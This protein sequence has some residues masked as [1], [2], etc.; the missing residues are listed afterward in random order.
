M[1]QLHFDS[2]KKFPKN[3]GR[4]STK[5]LLN[6]TKKEKITEFTNRQKIDNINE[7]T[8]QCLEIIPE[9]YSLPEMPR[10]KTKI[11]PNIKKLKKVALFDLDETIVH[12]I[13]E[14]NMNN[15]ENFTRQSDA[16]IKV[17]LPG[18][19]E[20]TIG[21]NIRPHWEEALNMIKDKYHIIAYTASHESYAD[22]VLKYLDPEN[23]YFEYKLYRSHCVLCSVNDMK[24][25]VKDL[26]IL[27]DFCD[28]KEVVL[29]DNSVLSFA[30][31]LDNGI[32]ISPFYDSKNDSELLDI[33]IFLFKYADEIDLRD[34][35][36]EVYKLSEYLEMIKIDMNEN[37]ITDSSSISIVQEDEESETT[38]KKSIKDD[39]NNNNYNNTNNTN[40]TNNINNINNINNK[41]INPILNTKECRKFK[42]LNTVIIKENKNNINNNEEKKINHILRSKSTSPK[43]Y[44][45]KGI[46]NIFKKINF[47]NYKRSRSFI[48]DVKKKKRNDSKIIYDCNTS[49]TNNKITNGNIIK[50]KTVKYRSF[51]CFDINFKK[52]WEEMQ[53]ALNIK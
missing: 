39:N 9:L 23:K 12:C 26:G 38:K 27:K 19:R 37:N 50:R 18:G 46:Q 49:K 8:R 53:K 28:L 6:K 29:I 13:G 22:S 48:I 10:C 25:Y 11:H 45:Y 16:K 30:Y 21:I 44:K 2:S 20:V 33:A 15:V 36:K 31:H 41:T 7:Y 4:Y 17:K 5:V 1:L 47:I 42:K 3:G 14:I 34:K 51:H 40:N 32:P 52:E 24:F 43:K 35:L